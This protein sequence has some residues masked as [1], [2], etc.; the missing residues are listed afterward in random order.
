MTCFSLMLLLLPLT[1]SPTGLRIFLQNWDLR[2]RIDRWSFTPKLLVAC[3]TTDPAPCLL[4]SA[5]GALL[6]VLWG[7]L[8]HW[9]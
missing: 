5:I 2:K 8:E 6:V 3:S 7:A 9:G 4:W 1:F